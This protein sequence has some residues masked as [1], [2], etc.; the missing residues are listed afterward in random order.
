MAISADRRH[1]SGVRHAEQLTSLQASEQVSGGKPRSRGKRRSLD[2]AMQPG[3]RLV[4]RAHQ[5]S[6]CHIRHI[7]KRERRAAYPLHAADAPASHQICMREYVARL[8]RGGCRLLD[9]GIERHE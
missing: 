8:V 7:N 6:L 3:E 5:R 9:R 1:R 2:L 4:G